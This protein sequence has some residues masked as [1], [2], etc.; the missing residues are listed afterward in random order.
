MN[1]MA[2]KISDKIGQEDIE[3]TPTRNGYGEGLVELGDQD[4]KVV[5]LT[6]DLSESTRSLAFQKKFPERFVEVG[7]AEQNMMGIA[8]G[9]ALSGKIP[10]VSSY[11]TFSPGRNWDQL[12]VSVAYSQ[13]NVKVAGAH[14]GVS[15]GPDG[16]THQALEDIAIVRALPNMVVVVPCDY[17]ETKKATIALGKYVGPAYLRFTREKSPVFTSPE[18]PFEIGK[19]NILRDGTDVAIIGCGPLL[20][21]A[22]LA[23]IEL[24]K[25]GINVMVV[26]NHTVKPIDSETI[27]EAAK[28]CGAVV[29]LEEHQVSAGAGSAICEV[30]AKNYPVPVEMIGMP[31]SFGESGEPD[32]LIKKYGMDKEAVIKAIQKVMQ[33]KE[34]NAKQ[35]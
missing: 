20:Y 8:A 26:N 1:N 2:V 32:Q 34:S 4:P 11:A 28:K 7:V 31:D 29:T 12:R 6:G 13:A 23:A 33:R 10:F 9:L 22:M 18:T 30:L 24:E 27:I 14:T 16:A 21:N 25:Q 15:V 19:A 5:V 17:L 3:Q 35:A